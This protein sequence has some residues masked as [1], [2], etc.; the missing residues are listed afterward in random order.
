MTLTLALMLLRA[1]FLAPLALVARTT[2]TLCALSSGQ[3]GL[4]VVDGHNLAYR[5]YYGM[6]PMATKAGQPAGALLGFVNKV[7]SLHTDYPEHN[8]LVAFDAGP[9]FRN[10]LLS[11]YKGSRKKMPPDLRTQLAAI[12]EA[13]DVLGVPYVAAPNFEADDVVAS[14]CAAARAAGN[15]E[16]VVVVSSDKDLLQL[17][18]DGAAGAT[19]VSVYCDK[20]KVWFDEAA[21]R[22]KHGVT[23]G[24]LVDYLALVGDASDDVPGVPGVGP[25]GAAK[26]LAEH[27]DL[28]S[29]LAAA[30]STMK[31]SKRRESL[32]ENAEEARLAR[33]LITL[34]DDVPLDA[35]AALGARLPPA[36]N[37]PDLRPFLQ[38]WEMAQLER[39]LFSAP[40]RAAARA[41]PA[42][43]VVPF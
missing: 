35:G 12:Y 3:R 13:C 23:P 37:Q 29:I 8:L 6:P 27:G 36:E 14:A 42:D 11:T 28:D 17:V 30:E 40:A 22:E 9:T 16:E 5:M 18:D 32:R 38:R 41:A 26:L 33:Q 31:K 24:Q 34:R 1:N 19:S 15:Y 2:R 25:K 20:K 7:V 4:V 21:V 10:D 43:N 39:R